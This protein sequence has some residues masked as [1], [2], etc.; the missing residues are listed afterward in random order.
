MSLDESTFLETRQS[1]L[2]R[3]QPWA[4]ERPMRL[5]VSGVSWTCISLFAAV[6]VI[7]VGL[8][9]YL[10]VT[11]DKTFDPYPY[12]LLNLVL[13]MPAAI[14]GPIIL[15][16]QNRQAERDRLNSEHHYEVNLKAELEIMLLH[17]KV[18]LLREGQWG[19][20]L[21]IQKDQL[22]LLGNS[23]EKRTWAQ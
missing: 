23:I 21:A 5:R 2:R 9:S 20:L 17:N 13:S 6:L 8:N 22:K 11:Y 1:S 12:I 7:W 19:E 3:R 18:D 16:S 14:Q 10:L 4:S 15:T